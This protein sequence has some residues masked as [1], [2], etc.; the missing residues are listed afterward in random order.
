MS[1]TEQ[2]IA[3]LERQVAELKASLKRVAVQ[4]AALMTLEEMALGRRRDLGPA[5]P[6]RRPRHLTVVSG[7]A[8]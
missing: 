1:T 2:R 7:G 5:V 8:R 3:E 4:A 6:P